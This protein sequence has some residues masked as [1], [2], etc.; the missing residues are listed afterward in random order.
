MGCA[1]ASARTGSRPV[2]GKGRK[3]AAGL[4][5]VGG[6]GLGGHARGLYSWSRLFERRRGDVWTLREALQALRLIN[7]RQAGGGAA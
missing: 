6:Q 7:R 4:G 5:R 1:V 2:A 3:S